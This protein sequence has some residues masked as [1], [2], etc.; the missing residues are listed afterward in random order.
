MIIKK[1]N[2]EESWLRKLVVE[3]SYIKFLLK[4]TKR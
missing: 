4:I 2:G 3:G 1:K